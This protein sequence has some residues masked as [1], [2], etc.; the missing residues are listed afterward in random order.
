MPLAATKERSMAP[1]GQTTTP[2]KTRIAAE[3]DDDIAG[4]IQ[5]SA[6]AP[7]HRGTMGAATATMKRGTGAPATARMERG[8]VASSGVRDGDVDS[9]R[10]VGWSENGPVLGDLERAR[11][12]DKVW[13]RVARDHQHVL[14]VRY[15]TRS[16]WPPGV[17]AWL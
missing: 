10:Q 2:P 5:C 16:E 13:R 14:L 1:P 7:G 15:T 9:A 8:A 4:I 3:L 6:R 12:L 17:E 11:R